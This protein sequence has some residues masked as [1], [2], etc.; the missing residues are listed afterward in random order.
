M[1]AKKQD[2]TWKAL[3][4]QTEKQSAALM[5]TFHR[6]EL[7]H[8][9]IPNC[10]R[11]GHMFSVPKRERKWAAVHQSLPCLALILSINPIYKFLP[12]AG[13]YASL[14]VNIISILVSV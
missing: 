6:P 1:G 5:P 4:D 10:K 7:R 8:M 12:Y 3:I 9:A 14:Y 2:Y 13:Y 11:A